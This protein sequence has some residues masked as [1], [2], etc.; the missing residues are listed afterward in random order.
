MYGI[1]AYS[2]A[3]V[4]EDNVLAASSSVA[5]TSREGSLVFLSPI[6]RGLLHPEMSLGGL[7]LDRYIILTTDASRMELHAQAF[8]LGLYDEYF[9][10]T[11]F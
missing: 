6:G 2:D 11:P 9:I 10:D 1:D 8:C 3:A 7:A 4:V 5:I